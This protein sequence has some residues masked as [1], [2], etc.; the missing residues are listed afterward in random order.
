MEFE[1]QNGLGNLIQIL[2]KWAYFSRFLDQP[3]V[4]CF[5]HEAPWSLG[6]EHT[7]TGLKVSFK[8]KENQCHLGSYWI[9]CVWSISGRGGGRFIILVSWQCPYTHTHTSFVSHWALPSLTDTLCQIWCMLTTTIFG[10][11]YGMGR[12]WFSKTLR[13]VSDSLLAYLHSHWFEWA[14]KH[15]S[16]DK[17]LSG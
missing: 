1:N 17:H 7:D 12:M 9:Q 8:S 14:T 16:W 11:D 2:G 13:R 15:L 10:N 6:A 3:F 4:S 5:L